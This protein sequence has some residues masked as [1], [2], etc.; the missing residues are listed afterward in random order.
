MRIAADIDEGSWLVVPPSF[1]TVDGRT[2]EEFEQ[3]F[4][5][6]VAETAGEEWEPEHAFLA[7]AAIRRAVDAV[8]PGDTL[9]LLFWPGHGLAT[10]VVHLQVGARRPGE[11]PIPLEEHAPGGAAIDVYSTPHLGDG[12]IVRPYATSDTGV[13]MGSVYY[14]V[15]SESGHLLLWSQPT[16]PALVALL[17]P[18]LCALV[19]SLRVEFD[20][21][22]TWVQPVLD[23][24]AVD[25]LAGEQWPAL[26]R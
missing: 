6:R 3:D 2:R 15:Q 25:R 7:E 20:D 12:V 8:D 19:D 23:P 22:T 11:D 9:T 13:T 17:L 26:A 4:V 14:L 16:I 24:D 18:E 1:P 21:A 5:R 10:A